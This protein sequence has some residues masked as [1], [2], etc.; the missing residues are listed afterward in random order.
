MKHRNEEALILAVVLLP[1]SLVLYSSITGVGKSSFS[2]MTGKS[3]PYG[4]VE[5]VIKLK[6]PPL[7]LYERTQR[8]DCC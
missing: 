4:C 6:A 7:K 8:S 5:V 3:L 1:I 2:V